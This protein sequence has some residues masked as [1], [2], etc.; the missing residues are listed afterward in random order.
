[1]VYALKGDQILLSKGTPMASENVLK[2][3]LAATTT[4]L[5]AAPLTSIAKPSKS[6]AIDIEHGEKIYMTNCEICHLIGRNLV[7]PEK[8]I[9]NSKIAD[10]ITKL[11]EF[12]GKK[13]GKMPPFTSLSHDD[14]RLRDLHSFLIYAKAH[15]SEIEKIIHT[16]DKEHAKISVQENKTPKQDSELK[17]APVNSGNTTKS[18]SNEAKSSQVHDSHAANKPTH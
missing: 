11:K 2:L 6:E 5:F 7:N 13:N 8:E 18:V 14:K 4:L 1:M 3:T 17:L 12:L 9:Q 15:P 16:A 10:D